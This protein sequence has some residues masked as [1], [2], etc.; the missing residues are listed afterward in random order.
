MIKIYTKLL[1]VMQTKLSFAG[2]LLLAWMFFL[3]LAY[4]AEGGL[5]APFEGA[6]IDH[7]L[8]TKMLSAAEDGYL[9]RI[10]TKSSKM[11]FCV[12][13]PIGLIKGDFK[14]FNGGMALDGKD[15]QTIVSARVSSLETGSALIEKMIKSKKFFDVKKYPEL[16]FVS[17]DFEWISSNRA[18]MKGD[19]SMHGVTKPVAF[20]VEI[21]ELDGELSDSDAIMIKA[22]TTVQRS[23][24]GME[25]LS[26][27][28]SDRVNLC[29]SVEAERYVA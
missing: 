13:S 19:L 10:N 7:S 15:N 20:Y 26:S 12:Q 11:G 21:I 4:S 23:E 29:M 5:C 17:T 24:F 18:V 28:V 1:M 14:D 6:E 25:T 27:M 8:I 16:L 22:T 3:P 2:G 9:Y